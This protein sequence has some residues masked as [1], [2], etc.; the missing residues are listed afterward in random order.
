MK[1]QLMNTVL[2]GVIGIFVHSAA[3]QELPDNYRF[4]ALGQVAEARGETGATE[5]NA[6][7][8]ALGYDAQARV[9]GQD[10]TATQLAVGY[11]WNRYIDTEF[12]YTDLGEV[13][14]RLSG[15]AQDIT[16]YLQSANIVHPRTASGYELALVVNWPMAEQWGFFARAAW[17]NADTDYRAF[18]NDQTERRSRREDSPVMGV[19][20]YYHLRPNITLR[21]GFNH[22]RVEDE[23]VD[24]LGLSLLYRFGQRH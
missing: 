18:G 2:A 11:H 15:V 17:L 5:M 4:Y 8:A 10:R 3:A 7:M 21:L 6:R 22:Y 16:D 23:D 9:S 24:T 1:Y 14:T 20:G 12:A 19:G 13:R